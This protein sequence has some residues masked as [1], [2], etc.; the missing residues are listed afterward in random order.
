MALQAIL[1]LE[2]V[3][4]KAIVD[5]LLSIGSYQ[6]QLHWVFRSAEEE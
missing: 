2:A 3:V 1:P 5:I 4:L 6:I